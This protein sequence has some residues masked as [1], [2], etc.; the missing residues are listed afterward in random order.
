MDSFREYDAAKRDAVQNG[1]LIESKCG[2]S[3][4]L[5]PTQIA[6]DKFGVINPYKRATSIEHAFYVHLAAHTLKTNSD[7][8]IK[9]ETPIGNK[10]QTIDITTTD[11]SGN[12]TAY[13]VTIST[14]NLSS[15]ASKL[16][17]S[18]YQK[19][20][21]LCRDAD[22]ANAVKAYF[23]KSASLPPELISKFEFEFFSKWTSK[24]NKRKK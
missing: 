23:N 3:L 22:T 7:L 18:A 9:I 2:K 12:L 15:N 16:Q 24:L 20:V 6:Y 17:N 5:I 19:I 1:F 11:K 14:S 10:G 21:W 8:T 13:E 4:Y